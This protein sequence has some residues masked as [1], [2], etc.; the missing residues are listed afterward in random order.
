MTNFKFDK[1]HLSEVRINVARDFSPFTFSRF[2][3]DADWS[4]EQFLRDYL[5]PAVKVGKNVIVELDG[6]RGYG[7]SWLE[8]VFGGVVREGYDPS[9]IVLVSEDEFLIGEINDYI[10]NAHKPKAIYESDLIR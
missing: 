8:E 6:T 2:E 3:K 4:G 5:I 1:G 10:A 7:S 9:A